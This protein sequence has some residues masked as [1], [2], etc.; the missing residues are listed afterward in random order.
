[1]KRISLL[2]VLVLTGCQTHRPCRPLEYESCVETR[3]R[4]TPTTEPD[5]QVVVSFKKKW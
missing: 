3:A 2:A 5:V 4:V 1:M